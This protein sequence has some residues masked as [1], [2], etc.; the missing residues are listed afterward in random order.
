ME[1]FA[2]PAVWTATPREEETAVLVAGRVRSRETG[3]FL[4]AAPRLRFRL[5]VV[6]NILV[7]FPV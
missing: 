1:V 3:I 4:D 6:M 2:F 5:A 7:S